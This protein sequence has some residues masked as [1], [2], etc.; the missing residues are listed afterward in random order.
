MKKLVLFFLC[1][2]LVLTGCSGGGAS[3]SADNS[4]Q[5]E[6]EETESKDDSE[7]TLAD[8]MKDP[9]REKEL[10][11]KKGLSI[12]Q[13]GDMEGIDVTLNKVTLSEGDDYTQLQQGFILM[14]LDV[15]ITNNTQ[16]NLQTS[17]LNALLYADNQDYYREMIVTDNTNFFNVQNIASGVSQTG[18][19]AYQ[20]PQNSSNF[21]FVINKYEQPENTDVVF[22]FTAN[23]ITH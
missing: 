7:T 15:T 1:L 16:A 10:A 8:R 18:T 11:A 13:T 9:E 5:T 21:E 22:D 2:L 17:D 20:V 3:N 4:S 12:G 23:D 19:F 6:Q 14:V